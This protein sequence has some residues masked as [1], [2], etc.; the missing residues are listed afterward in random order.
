V[1]GGRAEVVPRLAVHRQDDGA[2]AQ[3]L[4]GRAGDGSQQVIEVV[5]AADEP[6]DLEQP[7]QAGE[8]GQVL[9]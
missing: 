3:R 6:G 1:H 4:G 5:V 2:E 8:S 7:A 9:L